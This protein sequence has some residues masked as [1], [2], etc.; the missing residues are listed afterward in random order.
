LIDCQNLFCETDKYARVAYPHLEGIS[1]R[2][3]IKQAFR[4]S[5]RLLAPVF[6]PKWNLN[7]NLIHD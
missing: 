5:G 2:T 1:G 7:P 6:P 3:R 4:A